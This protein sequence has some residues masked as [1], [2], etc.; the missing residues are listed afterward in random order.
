MQLRFPAVLF[1]AWQ[2][3]TLT[4]ELPESSSGSPATDQ[5]RPNAQCT[6]SLCSEG[7]QELACS[8]CNATTWLAACADVS[9]PRAECLCGASTCDAI[10]DCLSRECFEHDD[11]P[12]GPCN[13]DGTCSGASNSCCEIKGTP[14]CGNQPC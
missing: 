8:T 6:T 4:T 14:S 11:C 2:G 10:D 12:E 3:C 9:H 7:C 1:L 13:P 5:A